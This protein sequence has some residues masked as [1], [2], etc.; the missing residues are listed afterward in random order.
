MRLLTTCLRWE[1]ANQPPILQENIRSISSDGPY[2]VLLY[3]DGTT[4][5]VIDD[6]DKTFR[7]LA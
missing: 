3:E 6:H 5:K 1:L 7:V 2:L 4:E